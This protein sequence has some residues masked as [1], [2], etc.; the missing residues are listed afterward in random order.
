MAEAAVVENAEVVAVQPTAVQPDA[1]G[2]RR[3]SIVIASLLAIVILTQGYMCWSLLDSS[4]PAESWT[5]IN[6]LM[7]H[8]AQLDILLAGGLLGLAKQS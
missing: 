7:R 1:K 5:L 2:I 4:P 8:L 3:W 6:E